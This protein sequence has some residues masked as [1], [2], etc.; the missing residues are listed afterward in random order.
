MSN[1]QP[2]GSRL[3]QG[4]MRTASS[5]TQNMFAQARV[6]PQDSSA[7]PVFPTQ[8]DTVPSMS[9]QSSTPDPILATTPSSS[10]GSDDLDDGTKMALFDEVLNELRP[11]T[12]PVE[13]VVVD[14]APE[15][16]PSDTAQLDALQSE[17]A[18]Q[19]DQFSDNAS[20]VAQA[21][22]MAVQQ[23]AQEDVQHVGGK[24][25]EMLESS[26]LSVSTQELPGGMQAIEEEKSPEL[27]PE[28][29]SYI[30]HVEEQAKVEPQT[31]V[32]AQE[33]PQTTTALP[34]P[35]RIVKVLPI[36]RAQEE[37]GMKK[38]PSFSIR[39]LVE[40]GHKIAKIFAGEVIYRQER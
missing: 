6:V 16:I 13:T 2:A 38:N 1:S 7:T 15:A 28:V 39:W 35:P 34:T 36:T 9:I 22:P 19:T 5:D 10:T 33:A 24:Q 12:A 40:F 8:S 30:Q 18:A 4:L 26:S 20:V 23:A 32:V 17:P 37:V 31:I 11:E 27:P 21:L 14:S 29:E 3:L 25:K